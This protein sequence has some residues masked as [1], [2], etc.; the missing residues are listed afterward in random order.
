VHAGF[1]PTDDESAI[2]TD[3]GVTSMLAVR[4]GPDQAQIAGELLRHSE[5]YLRGRGAKV[6]YGGA[7]HPLDPFYL[8]LY[9]GSELPGVLDSDPQAQEVF[10]T[11]GYR[12]IDRT[13]VFQRALEGFRAPVD[14]NH[15]Y[16]PRD[17]AFPRRS[18]RP[19][20]RSDR[21]PRR[22]RCPAAGFGDVPHLRGAQGAT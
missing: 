7:V 16:A 2:S 9:G 18:R 19:R 15:G 22:S 10:R 13:L 14:R 11:H 21:C 20:Q 6:L 8:G 12:E 4:P 3:L 17:R 1:G 5:D